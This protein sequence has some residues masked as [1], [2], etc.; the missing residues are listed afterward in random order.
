M[1]NGSD[2]KPIATAPANDDLELS[3]Y[4]EG[5]Y[6]A[7]VFPCRCDGSGWRDVSSN[8]PMPIKLT[9]WRLW[10]RNRVTVGVPAAPRFA[11]G[12]I[13]NALADERRN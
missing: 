4:D 10:Q 7:L 8:R 9:H 13:Q 2:W 1:D 12:I 3:M 6:H 11:S 5:E